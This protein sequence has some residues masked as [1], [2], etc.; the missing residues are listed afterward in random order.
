MAIKI[1]PGEY[2]LENKKM[3]K[4]VITKFKNIYSKLDYDAYIYID[5]NI[6]NLTVDFLLIDSNYGILLGKVK[7]EENTR[8]VINEIADELVMF[9]RSFES[10]ALSEKT[11]LDEQ[12][13]LKINIF[14]CL[15][16]SD[17]NN[18]EVKNS[19]INIVYND[20]NF[21]L[22]S[23]FSSKV[24][25]LSIGQISVI[26]TLICP[27]VK[28]GVTEKNE[29]TSELIATLDLE[30]EEF[31]KRVSYGH[32]WLSGIPGSGKT[33]A[34]IARAVH[35]LRENKDW[36]VLIV[37][38]NKSLT[39]KLEN[40]INFLKNDLNYHNISLN[41]LE[42]TN[43]HKFALKIANMSVPQRPSQGFWDE[44]LAEYAIEK[45]KKSDGIYD[46]ILIDEYQDF[47]NSWINACVFAL[48]KS[49]NNENK[50]LFIA[51]DRLQ[52][53]YNSSITNWKQDI[54]IDM[55]GK[56]KILKKSYRSAS[57]HIKLSLEFLKT[58]ADL[59]SEVIKFY[60]GE[61]G[62]ENVNISSNSIG[63]LKGITR[64]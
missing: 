53:I 34:L 60:D 13:S 9:S 16:L 52:S 12:F 48:N 5:I 50:N 41:K 38:Y 25:K 2:V 3:L 42:I 36:K 27:E 17:A 18:T 63:F 4:R 55:R 56:S 37:T 31:A 28:I 21:E 14:K 62:I 43:F 23:F 51:G 54:G 6:R 49:T 15:F 45:L 24:N 26:R 64:K 46:A 33:V 40:R 29:N 59:Q 1:F 61:E 58:D 35:I 22:S 47:R 11:L 19:N 44:E 39:K 8:Q 10:L 7:E 57:D 32:Y 20:R 30:Q